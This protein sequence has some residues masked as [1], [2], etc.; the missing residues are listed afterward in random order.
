MKWKR[1]SFSL[2]RKDGATIAFIFSGAAS[3][4][5]GLPI[6]LDSVFFRTTLAFPF[7]FP[8]FSAK[9]FL[10][11][12]KITEGSSWAVVD[13]T[14]LRTHVDSLSYFFAGSLS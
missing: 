13:A 8:V 3:L 12:G 2:P 11:T 14:W 9:V 1:M 4:H 10:D 7:L 6:G 5:V